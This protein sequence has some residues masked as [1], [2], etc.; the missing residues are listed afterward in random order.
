M[1]NTEKVES[2]FDSIKDK[3]IQM[4]NEY[5]GEL[6][7]QSTSA[8]FKRYLFAF[9]SVHTSWQNNCRGYNAIKEFRKWKI[10]EE[11]PQLRPSDQLISNSQ[12]VWRAKMNL[13]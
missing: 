2:F 6:K 1:I 10:E 5:W 4:Y 8:I 3:D 7:P 11:E 9:M 12:V 13:I